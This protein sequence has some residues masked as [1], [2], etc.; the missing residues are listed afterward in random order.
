MINLNFFFQDNLIFALYFSINLTH[1]CLVEC[2]VVIKTL[3]KV[4]EADTSDQSGICYFI[5]VFYLLVSW[6]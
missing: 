4:E 1:F 2:G 5:N 3:Q 6:I